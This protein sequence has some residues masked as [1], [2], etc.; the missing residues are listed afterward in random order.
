MWQD[1]TVRLRGREGQIFARQTKAPASPRN[2]RGR[3]IW[4]VYEKGDV[5]SQ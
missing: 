5:G 1:G 2:K 4:S 3:L